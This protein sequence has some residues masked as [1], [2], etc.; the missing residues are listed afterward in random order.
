MF[1]RLKYAWR[2][3]RKD[4]ETF[5]LVKFFTLT[6]FIVIALFTVLLT[7][8]VAD[9]L[10]DMALKKS[11]EYAALLAA[12]LNHQVFQQFV[13][14]AA[15]RF[16]GRIQISDPA[17][18]ELL[19]AVVRNTIHGFHVQ[20]VN[21]Y[22]Q[23]G[24]LAYS[25][26]AIELGK[27]YLA[28]PEV[29]QALEEGERN[30]R[31][32]VPKYMLFTLFFK[33]LQDKFLKTFNPLR[34][35]SVE[36]KLTPE[37]GPV[38]G[39]FEITQDIS[40]D[41]TEIGKFQLMLIATLIVLMGLLFMVLRQI[42]KKAETILERRQE[43]RKELQAQLELAERLAALGEMVA[44]VAHE[45]R[46]PLGIISS[47]AELLRKRL[48]QNE[49]NSRL[50]KI[51]EEEVNRL[52]QTVTEFLDFARPREPN[53][54]SCDVEGILERGLDFLKPEID[55]HHI[56]LTRQY[57][58][59]GHLIMVDPD[60]LYRA[61]LNI[62]INAI[63]AMPKGGELTVSTAAGPRGKGMRIEFQDSGEGITAENVK[64][65]FNPFFTTKDYGSGLG[66]SIVKGIIES[67]Q[68]QITIES[69]FGRGAKVSVILP[70]IEH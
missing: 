9:R 57:G 46:N 64:K 44:G 5:R 38:I 55:R 60:L 62:L 12:N 61:F 26:D 17:Q 54:R 15:I 29:K 24:D 50:A 45:I 30:I 67:H 21:I 13:L 37:L 28:V 63:Q 39:V 18:Y 27:N 32:A 6:G 49:A 35:E 42:V 11:E 10:Q 7:L 31:L 69:H 14:P 66:L 51:I 8:F 16:Q 3:N 58:R 20:Q 56:G 59:N 25:T 36:I 70:D 33:S 4:L 68:G 41:M 34:L 1:R 22:D 40:R 48:E 2:P 53:L 23:R 52:N 47:T 43:E 65:I 19:D